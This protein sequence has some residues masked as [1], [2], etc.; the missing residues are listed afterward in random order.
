M[1]TLKKITPI[2]LA[3][4]PSI[5]TNCIGFS[6]GICEPVRS[7][8]SKFDLDSTYPIEIAFQKKV[9]ELGYEPPRQIA[10]VNEAKENEYVLLVFDF[11]PYTVNSWGTK[12]TF[13][14]FHVVRRELNGSWVHK[15]GW[16]ESPCEVNNWEELFKEFGRK[17]VL[18]AFSN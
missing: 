11:T 18:F 9:K 7:S 8:S 12:V 17:Y 6:L 16:K 14:D 15:P 3:E 1:T 5:S 2:S 10:S 4:F 13:A